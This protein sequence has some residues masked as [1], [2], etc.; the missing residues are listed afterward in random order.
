VLSGEPLIEAFL[1]C[2]L[3]DEDKPFVREVQNLSL[4]HGFIIGGTV[5]KF[6]QSPSNLMRHIQDEIRKY[7][8]VIM[9]ATPRYIQEDIHKK[10][11]TKSI[12]EMLYVES[13]IGYCNDRPVLLFVQEGTSI[14]PVLEKI[15]E[16]IVL[17]GDFRDDAELM[18]RI[19]N[20]FENA[21]T[22]IKL[23]DEKVERAELKTHK[24]FNFP[25]ETEFLNKK[26]ELGVLKKELTV[27]K[28]IGLIGIGGLGK[29]QFAYKLLGAVKDQFTN[30]IDIYLNSATNSLE[31]FLPFAKLFSKDTEIVE[32]VNN[33]DRIKERLSCYRRN[34]IFIDNFET[35][36]QSNSSTDLR[37]VV[38][39]LESIPTNTQVLL[40]SRRNVDFDRILNIR[41]TGLERETGLLLFRQ[42]AKSLLPQNL[43]TESKD[44]ILKYVDFI[45]G[46]PLAIKV[47]AKNYR[48]GTFDLE[49]TSASNVLKLE[50]LNGYGCDDFHSLFRSFDYSFRAIDRRIRRYLLKLLIFDSPFTQDAAHEI[51]GIS[52]MDFLNSYETGFLEKLDI[53]KRGLPLKFVFYDFHP[54]IRA[55]LLIKR[56]SHRSYEDQ[57]VN[58]Y[59]KLIERAIGYDPFARAVFN[60]IITS[61][62]LRNNLKILQRVVDYYTGLTEHSKI[63]NQIGLLLTK[64]G[65]YE[66]ARQF[67]FKCLDV[68]S[69]LYERDRHTMY[70]QRVIN[71]LRNIG[72]SYMRSNK[73]LALKYC[74]KAL[75]EGKLI[76]YTDP[77]Q[78]I[79]IGD[80]YLSKNKLDEAFKYYREGYRT[81][82]GSVTLESVYCA[83]ALSTYYLQT[84]NIL[85]SFGFIKMAL[86]YL[87]E[88]KNRLRKEEYEESLSILLSN[89]A[90]VYNR[91]GMT[92]LS[93]ENLLR[94]LE[95]DIK[96]HNVHGQLRAYNN[97]ALYSY[98][99]EN[100][101]DGD[102]FYKK[103]LTLRGDLEHGIP[104]DSSYHRIVVF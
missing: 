51:L 8:C 68:D 60:S 70:K 104:I 71:D 55:F 93:V 21:R 85:K 20:Y 66:E 10:I 41:L 74:I 80:I 76:R 87:E 92:D 96:Y 27:G 79:E 95:L 75:D 32:L 90:R 101:R 3:R 78:F 1:S 77:M 56:K 69:L 100:I 24:P 11:Q 81:T 14:P 72:L 36:L 91:I 22:I 73:Q 31:F 86:K 42:N 103:F 59:V 23:N 63:C 26:H 30:I 18:Q 54:L 94:V 35:I 16:Y 2:S 82:L 65:F 50:D 43:P 102:M 46:H 49:N 52:R 62:Y 57:L 12:S 47:A 98:Q 17:K 88:L 33:P 44:E 83:S 29:S 28:S 6:T 89:M 7:Q 58:Y 64:I 61:Y 39:F 45:G 38:S 4:S 84:K 53:S 40:T 48:R 15:T 25:K 34:L 13:T 9:A 37:R 67:H 5:G 19:S 99:L 97:L